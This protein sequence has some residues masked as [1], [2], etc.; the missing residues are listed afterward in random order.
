MKFFGQPADYSEMLQRV[1][2]FSIVTGLICTFLLASA[3]PL[4]QEIVDSLKTEV[5]FGPIKSIKA[6]YILIPGVIALLSRIIKL[7]DRISDL[8][9]IRMIFDTKFFLYPLCQRAG[10]PLTEEIKAKL[11]KTRDDSMYQTVYKYA[12]YKKPQIDD[13]LV[14]TAAD[15][16]GWFWGFVESSFLFIVT[17]VILAY[18]HKWDYVIK[19]L[20]IILFEI[21]LMLILSYACIRSARPQV[22]AILNDT[23]RK[24]EIQGYFQSL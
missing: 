18:L 14:R 13:Q 16:W 10:V 23:N 12:G 17:T 8:L 15:N 9:W 20:Y 21:F 19:L 3:S 7:H 1:F 11:R 24:S 22:D 5:D 6:M 4:I 2:F